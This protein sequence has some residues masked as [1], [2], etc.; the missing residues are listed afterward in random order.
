[1]LLQEFANKFLEKVSFR[2]YLSGWLLLADFNVYL[3]NFVSS[4]LD[5]KVSYGT[6]LR[7]VLENR[8]AH[9]PV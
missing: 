5:K 6:W 4:P 1:M 7:F 9:L 8:P 3:K 2:R